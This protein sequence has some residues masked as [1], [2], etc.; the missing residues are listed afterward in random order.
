MTRS[1][2]LAWFIGEVARPWA[3]ISVSTA[4]A[5]AIFD[6]KEAGILTAAGIILLGLYT[7]KAAEVAFGA[8]KTADVEV[9]K[10]EAKK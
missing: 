9:A 2:R 10:V 5:W 8:K 7:A 3:L 4:V 1:E 6:G